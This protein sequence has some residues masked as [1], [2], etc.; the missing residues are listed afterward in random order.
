MAR[1]QGTPKTGGRK[2]GT[3]NKNT[4]GLIEA[5][6]ANGLS[7]IDHLTKI[8]PKLKPDKQADV[9]LA[10]MGFIYPKRKQVETP[11]A[12]NSD[13]PRVIVSIPSNG[14]ENPKYLTLQK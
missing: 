3:P 14:R 9:C 2:K 11:K 6:D 5:L 8:L 1:P 4:L 13:G 10:L 7:I 12:E